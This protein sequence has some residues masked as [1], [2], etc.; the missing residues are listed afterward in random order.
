[1]C[2]SSMITK[3]YIKCVYINGVTRKKQTDGWERACNSEK[4]LVVRSHPGNLNQTH[5]ALFPWGCTGL[6]K[7]TQRGRAGRVLSCDVDH[8]RK[9][10]PQERAGGVGWGV[11]ELSPPTGLADSPQWSLLF[12]WVKNAVVRKPGCPPQSRPVR[13][14]GAPNRTELVSPPRSGAWGVSLWGRHTRCRKCGN[15]RM[16]VRESSPQRASVLEHRQSLTFGNG[17]PLAVRAPC[18]CAPWLDFI[19]WLFL[20]HETFAQIII[21]DALWPHCNLCNCFPLGCF[22]VIPFKCCMKSITNNFWRKQYD[23]CGPRY[24]YFHGS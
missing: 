5:F 23:H 9:S 15:S 21:L 13:S 6:V 24:K 7:K 17:T 12:L 11:R 3:V 4:I 18:S 22:Y 20:C 14:T 8:E 1:M 16:P 2:V 19:W 10:R